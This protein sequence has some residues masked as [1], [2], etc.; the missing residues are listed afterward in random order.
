MDPR[1]QYFL[2]VAPTAALLAIMLAGMI[3]GFLQRRRK[4]PLASLLV[5]VGLIALAGNV[6][7]TV[8]VR[9][10][11]RHQAFDRYQDA[12]VV[13]EHLAALQVGLF[14]LNFICI[15]LVTAAVFADRGVIRIGRITIGSKSRR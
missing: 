10:Y 11:A 2:A 7:G 15:T 14:V 6:I 13:A 1:I 4:Q 3:L 9:V 8:A 12:T 5:I